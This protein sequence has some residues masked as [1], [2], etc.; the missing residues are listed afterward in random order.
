[1]ISGKPS[2]FCLL[3]YSAGSAVKYLQ[4]SNSSMIIYEITAIV[5]PH[6]IGD[7]EKYMREQHIPDL[8]ATGY[9]AAAFLTKAE[10]GRYRVQYHAHD[11]NA[12]DN[13]LQTEADRLRADFL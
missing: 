3:P 12:L 11:R 13:Y 1:M 2:S 8:L 7:Y 4:R 6:L 10:S 5:E 9:F